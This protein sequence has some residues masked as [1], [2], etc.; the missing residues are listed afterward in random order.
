M[1]LQGVLGGLEPQTFHR[2]SSSGPKFLKIS[3]RYN[4]NIMLINAFV[5]LAVLC[6]NVL[7]R[8]SY[9]KDK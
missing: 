4:T 8:A 7:I 3:M 6:S 9:T 2:T 5:K 1:V